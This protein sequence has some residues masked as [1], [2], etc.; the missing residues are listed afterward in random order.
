MTRQAKLT[1]LIEFT[2]PLAEL[3]AKLR[4]LGWDSAPIVVLQKKHIIAVLQRFALGELDANTVEEW[5]NLIES[6]EDIQEDV[7]QETIL[8]TAIHKPANP[9]LEGELQA[10]AADLLADLRLESA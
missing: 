1:S 9:L 6:R 8:S 4:M 5:A 3:E 2:A 10:I 7:G